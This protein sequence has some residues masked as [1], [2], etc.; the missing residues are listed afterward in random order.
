MPAIPTAALTQS[1]GAALPATA[2]IR[3]LSA[4]D[5]ETAIRL[6][7][8]SLLEEDVALSDYVLSEAGQLMARLR[9]MLDR[10][11]TEFAA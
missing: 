3:A 11:A 10:I 4:G 6:G 9:A 1:L 5:D 2:F 7:A 8:L